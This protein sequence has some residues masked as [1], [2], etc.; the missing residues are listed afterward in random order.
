[1]SQV[2]G[3][4]TPSLLTLIRSRHSV[5]RYADR[6]IEREKILQC[7]EAARWAPSAQNVQPWRFIVLDDPPTKDRFCVQVFS[8][9]YRPIRFVQRAP[10]LVVLLAKID[11]FANRIGRRLQGT[12]YY[13]IDIGIAGEH[14]VLQATELGIGTCWIGW[15]D[16]RAAQEALRLPGN[17][18]AVVLIA[19]GYPA[20]IPPSQSRKRKPIE[21]VLFFNGFPRA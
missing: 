21:E 19:M 5:R 7:I 10:A 9:I 14:F 18:K 12:P 17:Y 11:L 1:M 13:L 16:A 2:N 20:K 3:T 4:G 6:P 8:G 15:F